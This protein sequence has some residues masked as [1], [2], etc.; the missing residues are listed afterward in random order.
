MKK[1]ILKMIQE[2]HKNSNNN[3][4]AGISQV[5]TN[6]ASPKDIKSPGNRLGCVW[7]YIQDQA[8]P[9]YESM[10]LSK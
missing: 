8:K 7:L 1:S 10:S 9:F 6:Y 5:D 2:H 4:K 3:K